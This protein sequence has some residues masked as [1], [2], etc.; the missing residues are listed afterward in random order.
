MTQVLY[1]TEFAG[2]GVQQIAGQQ[3]QVPQEPPLAQQAIAITSTSAQSAAFNAAT[4]LVRLS[5]DSGGAVGYTFGTNPTATVASGGSGSA[6]LP[7]NGT[8]YHA[9]PK[10]QAFIVAGIAVT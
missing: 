10:N 8:E 2:L 3:M 7:A 1:I 9:V 5:A 4:T 6:R